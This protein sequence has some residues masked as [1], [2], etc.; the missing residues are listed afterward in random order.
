VRPSSASR[1]TEGTFIFPKAASAAVSSVVPTCTAEAVA[2]ESGSA[3]CDKSI[4]EG[5][6]G[7]TMGQKENYNRLTERWLG[8]LCRCAAGPSSGHRLGCVSLRCDGGFFGTIG[9][10]VLRVGGRKLM[11]RSDS[12]SR[13]VCSVLRRGL[14]KRTRFLAGWKRR[15]DHIYLIPAS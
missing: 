13:W 6:E 9:Y 4:I 10:S 15:S 5:R 12:D 1:E 14:S 2:E 11:I 8:P 3:A 7:T